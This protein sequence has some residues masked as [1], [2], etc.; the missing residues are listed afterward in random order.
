MIVSIFGDYFVNMAACQSG[1]KLQY[2][3]AVYPIVPVLNQLS[4]A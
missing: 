4:P 3:K 2:T 1:I